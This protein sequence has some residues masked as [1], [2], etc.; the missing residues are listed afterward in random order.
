MSRFPHRRHACQLSLYGKRGLFYILESICD[1]I[2]DVERLRLLEDK[3]ARSENVALALA[4][5]RQELEPLR[6]ARP[7]FPPDMDQI[8]TRISKLRRQTC[9][10]GA[11]SRPASPGPRPG[12]ERADGTPGAIRP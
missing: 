5:V 12:E 10:L 3:A 8:A 4:R 6:F 1:G 2:E 9:R 11:S 7:A